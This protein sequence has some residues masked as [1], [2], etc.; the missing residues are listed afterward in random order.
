MDGFMTLDRKSGIIKNLKATQQEKRSA[1]TVS[2]GLDVSAEIEWTQ[3]PSENSGTI[4]SQ[5]P[6]GSPDQKMLLLTLVTP[7]RLMMLHSR[8]WYVF[9]ETTDLVMLRM[10]RD[11]KLIGQCNIAPS[12]RVSPGNSTDPETFSSEVE[13]AL[14]TR[15]GKLLN[16]RV[17]PD[18]NGWRVLNVS[19]TSLTETKTILWDYYL[20]TQKSGEQFSLIFSRT[21]DDEP[22]FADAPEE[23]LKTLT[24][25]P[26]PPRIQVPK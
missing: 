10:L 12:V 19:A 13:A 9:H 14:A 22:A 5:L 16:S 15:K 4:P 20:C 1:G 26:V 2:P 7:S 17:V 21:A 24:L 3:E 6:E 8:D 23:I 25:R 11:G 18:L